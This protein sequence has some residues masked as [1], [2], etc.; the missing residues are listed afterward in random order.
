MIREYAIKLLE[1]CGCDLDCYKE[2]EL[3]VVE[4]DLISYYCKEDAIEKPDTMSIK[5]I[6]RELIK[7]G[8][9]QPDLPRKGHKKYLMVFDTDS[10]IDGV[11]FD[12]LEEA[13]N[14][15]LET[16]ILWMTE[17]QREWEFDDDGKPLLEEEQIES[18]DYMI[19][20]CTT[21]VVEWND[22]A[23]GYED[24]DSATFLSDEELDKIG[25]KYIYEME[26]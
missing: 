20:N 24:Y 21:Y 10:S 5:E 19:E 2:A 14:D 4:Q 9:E 23:G 7:I 15:A 16:R 25:W 1:T 6:A 17:E 13:L 3:G 22:E 11:E 18:W 8:N 26:Y 12:T